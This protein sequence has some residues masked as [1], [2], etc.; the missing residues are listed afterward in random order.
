MVSGNETAATGRHKF[1]PSVVVHPLPSTRHRGARNAL[2][3]FLPFNIP[4]QSLKGDAEL[5]SLASS[6][7]NETIADTP[8]R[9]EMLGFGR[10][11]FDILSEPNDKV[12]DRARVGILV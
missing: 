3:K 5:P 12:V 1:A 10:I 2:V 11:V 7:S 9:L 4:Q 6:L 8:D